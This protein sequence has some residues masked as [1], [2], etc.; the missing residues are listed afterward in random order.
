MTVTIATL[1]FPR[2]GPRRELKHALESFWSGKSG[3][4]ALLEA[5]AGLRTAAWARHLMAGLAEWQRP[6]GTGGFRRLAERFLARLEQDGEGARRGL[7][8]ATGDLVLEREGERAR[9]ALREALA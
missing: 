2:I 1:G 8:P 4:T 5:A 7:D 6:S 9:R 3:E